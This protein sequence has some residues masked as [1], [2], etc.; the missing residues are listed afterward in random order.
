MSTSV[1]KW[2]EGFSNRV[3]LIIRR[4][5]DR[6]RFAAYMA[7]SL[8]FTNFSYS[9][10]SILYHRIYGCMF[11]V[12]L[13][14]FFLNY[15]FLFLYAFRCGYSVSLRCSVYCVCVNVYCTTATAAT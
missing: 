8:I 14:N 15:V 1:V 13:F 12:R 6:T 10:G 2:S 3:S 9:F 7:V 11:C 5:R 4:C